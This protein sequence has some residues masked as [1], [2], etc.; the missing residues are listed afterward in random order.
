MPFLAAIYASA[1]DMLTFIMYKFVSFASDFK[2]SFLPIRNFSLIDTIIFYSSIVL[3]IMGIKRLS[4][5]KSKIIF[6]GLVIMNAIFFCQLDNNELFKSG[7]LNLMV[8]DLE[9]GSSTLIKFP[10]GETA[11]IDGGNA[12]FYFDS[13]ERTIRPLLNHLDVDKI[14][15]A[16]ISSMTQESFGGFISL[17]RSNTFRNI[18][19]I[20]L[21]SSSC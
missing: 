19:K 21:D 18:C 20:R 4:T 16:F 9:R 6:S 12:S 8:I 13:G 1:N 14:D 17:I 3:L 2:Y 15:Y 11:M 5:L 10:N 7:N